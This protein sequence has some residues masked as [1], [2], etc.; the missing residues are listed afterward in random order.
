MSS[1][2]PPLGP[3]PAR[4]RRRRISFVWVI[5]LIAA[6][7]ALYLGYRTYTEQ[8][9]L[10]TLTFNTAD[11][12]RAGQTQI[13]YKA[14][15]LGTVESIDLSNDL[16][17]VVIKIRMTNV[18]AR[19]LTDHAR[20]WV[21]RAHFT[22]SDPS[23]L[24]TFVSGAYIAVDPGAAGGQ[25]QDRFTGLE[26]PPG[27][28]SDE[29][30]RTY[31]LTTDHI[32][33]LRTGSPVFYRD[34]IVGEVLGYD[35]GDGLDPIKI[36][37]FVPAP[38]DNLVRPAS[39]FWNA[40]GLSVSLLPGALHVEF[41]SLAAIVSGGIAFD[42]PPSA[43]ATPPSPDNA[44][45]PLYPTIRDAQ[46]ASY[47]QSIPAVAYFQSSVA[48]LAI[49][50]PVTIY[51][52]QVGVVTD[53]SLILDPNTAE[54]SVRVA[55][56]LQ[57]ARNAHQADFASD[58]ATSILFQKMLDRGLRAEL[59]S[60]SLL[61]GQKDIQL[62]DVPGAA[63]LPLTRE[64]PAF[65]IPTQNGG[66]DN[67]IANLNDISSKLDK[68]PF[69][70]IGNNLNKLLL[71]TSGTIGSKATRQSL[72]ALAKTLQSTNA[73]LAM[74]NQDYGDDSDFQRNLDQVLDQATE[75]L[76]SVKELSD[77]LDR[78]PNALLL[79]RGDSP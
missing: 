72:A 34:A 44:A 46:S 20:F 58:Q 50:A 2:T 37:I 32:G 78:H 27:V 67:T 25:Y 56:S 43:A 52:M 59:G 14:V 65:I 26:Q 1:T 69:D 42:L 45:F 75:T 73:T 39:H 4:L 9:P 13:K 40:S 53:V 66:L 77:F 30:G 15:A 11:G 74:F 61:T 64:G 68:I 6:L 38:F 76:E 62:T 31:I 5:P 48:G 36:S 17:H 22:L 23:S 28:R 60:L 47:A 35:L 10:L 12:L 29:P 19:F 54:D 21:V 16:S 49:G 24:D 55:M 71:T 8:G 51:G 33:S 79:G 63:P 3:P 57:P 70:Q 18:G 7:I 41:E